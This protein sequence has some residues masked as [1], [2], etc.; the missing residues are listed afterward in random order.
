MPASLLEAFSNPSIGGTESLHNPRYELE[1]DRNPALNLDSVVPSSGRLKQEQLNLNQQNQHQIANNNNQQRQYGGYQNSLSQCSSASLDDE[2]KCDLHLYH[3]L[4]C[5]TCRNK[6]KALL[7][8]NEKEERVEKKEVSTDINKLLE[9]LLGLNINERINTVLQ[10]KYKEKEEKEEKKSDN[11]FLYIL[12]C[13]VFLYLLH[14]Y[15][16]K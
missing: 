12:I 16:T 11:L 14:F 1:L 4:S 15:L 13:L 9:N 7:L 8:C 3:I 2:T 6:L 10:S 5:K